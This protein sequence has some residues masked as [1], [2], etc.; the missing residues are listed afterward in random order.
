MERITASTP[1]M[2]A[3]TLWSEIAGAAPSSIW[4]ARPRVRRKVNR[5]VGKG[6]SPARRWP[7]GLPFHAPPSTSA[8]PSVPKTC[9]RQKRGVARI[10]AIAAGALGELQQHRNGT[11][12]GRGGRVVHGRRFGVAV[13]GGR[14]SPGWRWEHGA[15]GSFRPARPN[16]Y[17]SWRRHLICNGCHCRAEVTRAICRRFPR[18]GYGAPC[19]RTQVLKHRPAIGSPPPCMLP[20]PSCPRA[21]HRGPRPGG[22]NTLA[23]ASDVAMIQP[24]VRD[25]LRQM[26]LID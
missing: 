5:S 22:E 6:G 11:A 7:D 13:R 10:L 25:F 4:A 24:G 14:V 12:W 19:S 16:A 20:M 1:I 3:R 9:N 2:V 18:L 23:A 17:A 8:E 26:R 15:F 21:C